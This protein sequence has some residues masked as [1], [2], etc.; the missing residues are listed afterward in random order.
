MNRFNQV[1]VAGI[2]VVAAWCCAPQASAISFI[3]AAG[4]MDHL[5]D[6]D[7]PPEDPITLTT[8]DAFTESPVSR[9]NVVVG[10]TDISAAVGGLGHFTQNAGP[11]L[12]YA[13]IVIPYTSGVGQ[14]RGQEFGTFGPGAST[15][16]ININASWD[17]STGLTG[18]VYVYQFLM[19]ILSVTSE[20]DMAAASFDLDYSVTGTSG[21]LQ[22]SL[23][24]LA[25]NASLSGAD[26]APNSQTFTLFD[27]GL[28][29]NGV[30]PFAGATFTINGTIT[31]EATDPDGLADSALIENDEGAVLQGFQSLFPISTG[32]PSTLAVNHGGGLIY[33]VPFGRSIVPEPTTAG[34]A[35]LGVFG[36]SYLTRRRR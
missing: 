19:P 12:D 10:G 6:P 35:M 16:T 29:T 26:G 4:S 21:G 1:V 2:A 28:L 27:W 7:G 22:D 34:L 15:N 30:D 14:S 18:P 3:S 24:N 33:E 5:A 23:V 31:F 32:F 20:V 13:N 25:A 8:Y 11:G 36:V 9:T 17:I